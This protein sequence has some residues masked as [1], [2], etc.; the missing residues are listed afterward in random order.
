MTQLTILFRKERQEKRGNKWVTTEIEEKQVDKQFYEN[1]MS[2]R[3]GKERRYSTYTT[4]GYI[5]T[6]VI[7]NSPS[8]VDR[9]VAEFSINIAMQEQVKG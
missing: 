8:G 1:Y 3:L 7:S 4:M 9:S 6:K 2:G 5:P